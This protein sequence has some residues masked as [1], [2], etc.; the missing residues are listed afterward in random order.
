MNNLKLN[1][2]IFPLWFIFFIPPVVFVTLL[3]NL[4]IDGA[5]IYSTLRLNKII[6]DR[7]Q[8][9][10]LILKAW[11]FG[12]LA[13]IVGAAV[14][15]FFTVNFHFE[16]YKIW[17]SPKTITLFLFAVCLTGV[18]IYIVN[19]WLC[20]KEQLSKKVSV[21]V[22]ITMAIITAPWMFLIPTPWVS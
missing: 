16:H 14:I 10:A 22:G 19:H 6:L 11:I 18:I 9:T 3:G 8:I 5:V 13:D 1:N 15:F 21:R 17:N 20:Q 12:F 7:H 4:V 2:L